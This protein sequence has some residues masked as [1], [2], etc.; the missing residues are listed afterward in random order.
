MRTA[1]GWLPDDLD[2]SRSL[3]P[4]SDAAWRAFAPASDNG[5][6]VDLGCG[7]AGR[8]LFFQRSVNQSQHR[9]HAENSSA[10]V[11]PA[12]MR[13]DSFRRG[14]HRLPAAKFGRRQPDLLCTARS[15]PHRQSRT[16]RLGIA[17]QGGKGG[18]HPAA[19]Q[20]YDGGL[21]H[22]EASGEL[23]RARTHASISANSSSTRGYS[24]RHSGYLLSAVRDPTSCNDSSEIL[25]YSLSYVILIEPT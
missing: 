23:A 25:P 17:A 19:L 13:P 9:S 22:A 16:G 10:G 7:F 11:T 18:R 15:R 24:L 14:R 8:P 5:Q 4:R 21:G 2:A 1:P 6:D 20:A 3:R 12:T